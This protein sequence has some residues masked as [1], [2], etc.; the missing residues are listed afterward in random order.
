M[1]KHRNITLLHFT[2]EALDELKE[3]RELI[4]SQYNSTKK[5]LERITTQELNNDILYYEHEAARLTMLIKCA[6]R[7]ADKI[8]SGEVENTI[9]LTGKE[10][11]KEY[12]G[13]PDLPEDY[14]TPE[15][16][17]QQRQEFEELP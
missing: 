15:E 13:L 6:E 2:N 17:E 16:R 4:Y 9:L 8:E 11:D 12:Q 10:A 3:K 14:L 7:L 1:I 5:K